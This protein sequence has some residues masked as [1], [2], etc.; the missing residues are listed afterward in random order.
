MIGVHWTR[1]RWQGDHLPVAF[2]DERR[3]LGGRRPISGHLSI[4]IPHPVKA[5]IR[6]LHH[7]FSKVTMLMMM[8]V[9][10]FWWCCCFSHAPLDLYWIPSGCGRMCRDLQTSSGLMMRRRRMMMVAMTMVSFWMPIIWQNGKNVQ[11]FDEDTSDN[12]L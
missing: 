5:F 10:V 7:E 9:V 12:G 1:S 6:A 4:I 2:T 11:D 8:I 3:H